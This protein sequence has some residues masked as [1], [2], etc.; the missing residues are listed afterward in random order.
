[1]AL[2]KEIIQEAQAHYRAWNEAKFADR[3]RRGWAGQKNLA[4]KWHEYLD[5]MEFGR[6]IRP[7]PSLSQQRRKWAN[8]A[9]Y[10]Q[11]I[12]QFEAWRQERGQ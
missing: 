9:Q 2:N 6:Q 5:L 1:M 3:A 10:Y 12:Q 7:Q 8:L 4:Q 11:R